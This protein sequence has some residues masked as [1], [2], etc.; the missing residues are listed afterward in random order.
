MANFLNV[1]IYC[2]IKYGFVRFAYRCIIIF[3]KLGLYLSVAV[4]YIIHKNWNTRHPTVRSA[5]NVTLTSILSVLWHS[6]KSLC[7]ANSSFKI[8]L[9]NSL[10]VENL[11]SLS[12]IFSNKTNGT[13]VDF[14]NLIWI[15]VYDT[16]L[17][18]AFSKRLWPFRKLSLPLVPDLWLGNHTC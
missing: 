17:L 9:Y 10:S 12:I 18:A 13:L 1:N 6:P 3:S 5:L 15:L 7:V 14:M 2:H 4:G 16:I 11:S 8:F